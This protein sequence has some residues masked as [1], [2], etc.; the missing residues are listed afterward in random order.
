MSITLP[1][2]HELDEFLLP[3]L[4]AL[5]A[6]IAVLDAT[7]AIVTVNAPWRRFA[8]ANGLVSPRHGVDINYLAVCD[9]AMGTPEAAAGRAVA[10][11]IRAVL[12]DDMAEFVLVYPCHS[13]D[14]ERWFLMRAT[15]FRAGGATYVVVAHENIT[16]RHRAEE[17]LRRSEA[18]ARQLLD[19]NIIGV[20]VAD[21][22]RIIEANGAFL[23]MVGYTDADVAAGHVR[24]PEMTPPEYASR[25]LRALD[26]LAATG[27]CTPFEK[28]YWRRDGTRVPVL[29]G[30]TTLQRDPLQWACFI[31]DRTAH[32]ALDEQREQLLAS[33]AHDL[34]S[35]LTTITG[36]AQLL[37]RRARH[38]EA[39]DVARMLPRLEA[40][41]TAAAR[42]AGMLDELLDIARIRLG[43][44]LDLARGAVDL[45]ALAR[46]MVALHEGR[47]T[48]R[49][50]VIAH[51]PELVGEWDTPRLERVLD[52]LLSNA[53]KYSPAG[54]MIGVTVGRNIDTD[55]TW[56]V[57]TVADMG[58]GIP[59]ADLP[60][61]T[62]RFYRAANVVGIAEGTG[63]GLAGAK[64]IVAQHGG[65]ISVAS[66]E[67]EGTTVTVQLP[68]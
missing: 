61:I 56:A 38:S 4:D 48:H 22:E 68:T 29:I 57:L 60:R 14:G 23:R 36:T 5:A 18:R 66:T 52:N 41:E 49:F 21:R 26:E 9:A 58:I 46:R 35:P 62:E 40:I 28:E 64:Q 42:M 50:H 32:Q 45:V 15:R 27:T 30:A 10:S 7:G 11:G 53:R 3:L 17:A 33:V 44:P 47:G 8:D 51:E 43:R 37:A 65:T 34:K 1:A 67:R 63:I 55:G 20:V 2:P 39:A 16:A 13:P 6:T 25:D 31:L 19:A 59:A 12:A 54:S 24:W